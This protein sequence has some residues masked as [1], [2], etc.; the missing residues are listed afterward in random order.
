LDD[1]RRACGKSVPAPSYGALDRPLSTPF[2][3]LLRRAFVLDRN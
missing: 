3:G 2:F 1:G